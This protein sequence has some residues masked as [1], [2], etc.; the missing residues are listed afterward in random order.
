ML[1]E[2]GAALTFGHAAPDAE[3]D[4]IVEGVGAAFQNHRAVPADHSGF[5]L[6][7]AADE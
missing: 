5:A 2:Q 7:G 1:L 3:L 4:A 6:G